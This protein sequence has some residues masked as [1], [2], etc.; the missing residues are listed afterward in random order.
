M[1]IAELLQEYAQMN[2][3]FYSPC[4]G[5]VLFI[6]IVKSVGSTY[7]KT[8]TKEGDQIR[9]FFVDGRYYTYGE[10]VLFPSVDQRDWQKW[11]EEKEVAKH[12]HWHADDY[13]KFQGGWGRIISVCLSIDKSTWY[14][15]LVHN[16]V[17]NSQ[18]QIF[19]DLTKLDHFDPEL[20]KPFD[21]VLVRDSEQSPWC[22]S[23]FSNMPGSCRPYVCEN[24]QEYQ[25]CIPY[26]DETANLVGK[27]DFP[28]KFYC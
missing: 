1:N 27:I 22:I 16:Y 13:V 20:L 18:T 24:F 9:K 3:V 4:F 23:H 17:D 7:I 2:E 21:K 8:S 11:K 19:N 5:E 12:S 26:N 6:E 10:C 25:F 14:Y 15:V 28:H